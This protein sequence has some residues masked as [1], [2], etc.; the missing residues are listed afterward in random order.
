MG[1]LWLWLLFGASRKKTK[2]FVEIKIRM[3]DSSSVCVF[4][5]THMGDVKDVSCLNLTST[6]LVNQ[7]N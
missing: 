1:K 6:L 2:A 5:N 7:I 4:I 3:L